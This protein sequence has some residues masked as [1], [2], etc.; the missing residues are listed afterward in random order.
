MDEVK[1][2]SDIARILYIIFIH[3]G[4]VPVEYLCLL[5]IIMTQHDNLNYC[6]TAA[7]LSNDY[8]VDLL[9][10]REPLH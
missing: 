2:I 1:N 10:D 5:A 4:F 3:C 7:V 8:Y 9:L 6:D